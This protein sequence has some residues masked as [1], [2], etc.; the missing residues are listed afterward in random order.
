MTTEEKLL[1]N[2]QELLIN[3]IPTEKPTLKK[4]QIKTI[5][6]DSMRR[7]DMLKEL[8]VCPDLPEGWSKL[9][10][11]ELKELLRRHQNDP[12]D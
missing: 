8:K 2:I 12:S 1:F 11:I 5:D 9:S 6:I 7:Q 10:N 4:I 3:L